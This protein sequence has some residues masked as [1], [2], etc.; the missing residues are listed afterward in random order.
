MKRRL[1]GVA[2]LVIV[3]SALAFL[4]FV[5][6]VKSSR[7]AEFELLLT[8]VDEAQQVQ[9]DGPPIACTAETLRSKNAGKAFFGAVEVA[10]LLRGPETRLWPDNIA[11]A[12]LRPWREKESLFELA[13]TILEDPPSSWS[14]RLADPT[15]AGVG[16]RRTDLLAIVTP[17]NDTQLH[18]EVRRYVTGEVACRGEL[19]VPSGLAP[20]KIHERVQAALS[21]K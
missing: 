17:R 15:V 16:S 9:L 3:A 8:R 2:A 10:T 18:V 1:L 19:D 5:A 4:V 21:G 20:R 11:V 6:R 12:W 7:Q 14:D 13:R